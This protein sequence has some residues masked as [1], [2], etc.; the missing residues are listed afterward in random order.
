MKELLGSQLIKF[1]LSEEGLLK[2][3]DTTEYEKVL[4]L[5]KGQLIS[6]TPIYD[7]KECPELLRE[8]NEIVV[9]LK[10]KWGFNKQV[11]FKDEELPQRNRLYSEQHEQKHA[12]Y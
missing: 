2:L 1:D 9:S 4:D 5:L 3:H 7:L 8:L 6:C 11:Q 12:G 10:Q